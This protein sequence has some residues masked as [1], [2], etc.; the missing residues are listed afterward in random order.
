MALQPGSTC[1]PCIF[2]CRSPQRCAASLLQASQLLVL[3]VL[4]AQTAAVPYVS[5]CVAGKAGARLLHVGVGRLLPLMLVLSLLGDLAVMFAPSWP[6]AL[7]GAGVVLLYVPPCAAAVLCSSLAFRWHVR[8][9]VLSEQEPQLRLSLR[10]PLLRAADRMALG[11]LGG[12]LGATLLVLDA[13]G[14]T[15]HVLAM[16]GHLGL[17]LWLRGLTTFAPVLDDYSAALAAGDAPPARELWRSA[18]NFHI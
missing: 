8:Q 15:G 11:S 13:A 12:C 18:A 5:T 4:H 14:R 6:H 3:A 1:S 16:L 7:S 17:L 2:S 9:V 10:Q